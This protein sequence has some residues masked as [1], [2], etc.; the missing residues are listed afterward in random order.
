MSDVS[1]SQQL[2]Q[3][4]NTQQPQQQ[5]VYI[6]DVLFHFW[7]GWTSAAGWLFMCGILVPGNMSV[8]S[9]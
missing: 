3:Y 9:I 6:C 8:G 1:I 4:K 5:Y 2:E 7:G